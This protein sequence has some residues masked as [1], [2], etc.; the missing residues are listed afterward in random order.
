MDIHEKIGLDRVVDMVDTSRVGCG[1]DKS[2]VSVR[3]GS[4]N[5]QTAMVGSV[6]GF[7]PEPIRTDPSTHAI[8]NFLLIFFFHL[9]KC[10]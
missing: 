5:I 9:C 2:I 10:D 8:N 6:G 1:S 3:F 4:R 7:N